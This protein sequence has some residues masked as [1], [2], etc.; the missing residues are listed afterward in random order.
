MFECPKQNYENLRKGRSY[1]EVNVRISFLISVEKI[2]KTK[3]SQENREIISLGVKELRAR[4]DRL[5]FEL[6]KKN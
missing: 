5:S 1:R 2:M 3:I 4:L 6:T